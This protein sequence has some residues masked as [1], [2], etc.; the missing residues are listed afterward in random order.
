MFVVE[1]EEI[2]VKWTSDNRVISLYHFVVVVDVVF[3]FLLYLCLQKETKALEHE[4][5]F[6]KQLLKPFKIHIT[7]LKKYY[8]IE[9]VVTLLWYSYCSAI[10]ECTIK[11]YGMYLQVKTNI[12]HCMEL[13]VS[14][15][16]LTTSKWHS[17]ALIP[18]YL[19]T[20]L[21]RCAFFKRAA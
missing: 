9:W 7:V 12:F 5:V 11:I 18:D 6:F 3:I 8:S 13:I 1:N 4:H 10:N 19:S 21:L 20:Y 14:L 17:R 16:I 2:N 15:T